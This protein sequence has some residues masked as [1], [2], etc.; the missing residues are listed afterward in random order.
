VT[1]RRAGPRPA[2]RTSLRKDTAAAG[3][4][5]R[6]VLVANR[7]EIAV[8]ILR[9]CRELGMESV[10]VY[11][12]ADAGAAH[13]R[14]A[15]VA[16]RLGP[17][18][19]T[20][21]Y[22]RGQAIVRAAVTTG[23]EAIHPGYG[24]LA[25]RA[26]FARAVE[27]AGVVF[28]GPSSAAIAALGDK[29]AARRIA[30][31]AD[32]P[33]VPGTLAPAAVDRPDAVGT[34]LEEADAIGFPLLVKAAAG[35]GGRGMRRVTHREDLAAALAAG[36]AESLAAFGDG[37][38]YLEREI[39][40][41]RH[42]EVQ[43]LGDA[44]GTVVALG[45]RDCSIQR[46]HQKLVEESPAPGLTDAERAN[47]HELAVRVGR[48]A[49]VRSA[50]TAEF[51]FD[52]DRKP[53][54]L[55]VNARLQVE[56][57]VTELVTGLD[58]VAEQFRIAAGAPLSPEVLNAAAR[59]GRPGRHAIE[60]RLSAEDPARDF[61]PA[62]GRIGAWTMPAGPGV[63]VD[64]AV[65]AGERVPPDYDPLIAKVLAVAADRGAAID[66]LRRS[67]DEVA[68]GGIQTTLPFHRF[69]ARHAGFAAGELSIDWVAE[70]WDGE[71]DRA[72]ALAKALLAAG[73]A[74]RDGVLEGP[75][76]AA[77]ERP[78]REPADAWLREG[79]EAGVDRW[80]R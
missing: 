47:L 30:L 15:D 19:A 16:V 11:S 31:E 68:V 56:H 34:V 36:A 75:A 26:S 74:A 77:S 52:E 3:P 39:R 69:V 58:L 66:R 27:D 42:I 46:R 57:G 4:P 29:L 67:L 79:R 55:E 73:L 70:H 53:W 48:A 51:L 28:V 45:E 41:A 59:A 5:F 6:R 21:S 17:A 25:E 64:T 24:F 12:D 63:R 72:R 32:V 2:G 18:P 8:R 60:V 40:P 80:P 61:A 50:A 71:A 44:A 7:G 20:E 65:E 1:G 43:L 22:L 37:S 35:G 49:G 10:A 33:V 78:R 9:A 23:S 76:A 14:L 13:V 54:F 62:P 38:V